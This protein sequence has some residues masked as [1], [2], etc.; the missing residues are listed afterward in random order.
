MICTYGASRSSIIPSCRHS[1]LAASENTQ[2]HRRTML[3]AACDLSQRPSSLIPVTA[4]HGVLPEEPG[5]LTKIYNAGC[6]HRLTSSVDT[7]A[8]P[9][10][11]ATPAAH[12][13]PARR[14]SRPGA[15]DHPG[16]G[17]PVRPPRRHQ[18]QD[19]SPATAPPSAG[20]GNAATPPRH[21]R[22]GTPPHERGP[23]CNHRQRPDRHDPRDRAQAWL[24]SAMTRAGRPRRRSRGGQLGRPVRPGPRTS[25]TARRSPRWRPASPTSAR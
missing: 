15:A 19:R 25:S 3:V 24:R 9:A 10:R 13:P 1:L 8:A 6:A 4:W 11:P 21:R 12:Q 23:G 16:P 22:P 17:G 7:P 20:T 18:P 5:E 14:R 2:H